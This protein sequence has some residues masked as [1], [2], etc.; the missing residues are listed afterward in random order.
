VA[1]WRRQVRA[2]LDWLS[3]QLPDDE[4]VSRVGRSSRS[5]CAFVLLGTAWPRAQHR[6]GGPEAVRLLSF[7]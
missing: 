4:A 5:V 1:G 2:M 7:L 3:A 6:L